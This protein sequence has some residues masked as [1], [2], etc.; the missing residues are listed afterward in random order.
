MIRMRR[1][2]RFPVSPPIRPKWVHGLPLP[3]CVRAPLIPNH[4]SGRSSPPDGS[5]C[6]FV[7]CSSSYSQT[8]GQPLP[9]LCTTTSRPTSQNPL[10][11]HH[12]RTLES[13]HTARRE[14][15]LIFLL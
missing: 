8:H 4:G 12:P 14:H 5:A 13:S 15:G 1:Q 7:R 9:L 11:T 3:E 10:L 6:P 2:A